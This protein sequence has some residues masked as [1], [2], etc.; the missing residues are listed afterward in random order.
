M[1]VQLCEC[2]CVCFKAGQTSF[3]QYV[4]YTL[5][6]S[7]HVLLYINQEGCTGHPGKW[8]SLLIK[9]FRLQISASY[10]EELMEINAS[11]K[12]LPLTD[13]KPFVLGDAGQLW[14]ECCPFPRIHCKG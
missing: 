7:A 2:M 12:S 5:T 8:L 4:T 3:L 10:E 14:W 9:H 13:K 6:P 1:T 11:G